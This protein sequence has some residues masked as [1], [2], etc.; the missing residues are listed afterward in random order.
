VR[1]TELS[2]GRWGLTAAASLGLLGGLA[3][4]AIADRPGEQRDLR[5]APAVHQAG[6]HR[7]FVDDFRKR[8]NRRKWDTYSG[9]PGDQPDAWWAPSHVVV[10]H[11]ALTLRTY[12][13]PN[14]GGRWVSGGVSSSRA[15]KQ[16]YG[17]YRVRFRIDRGKGVAAVFLLWPVAEHWPPEIDFAETGGA[18]N[19]RREMSAT[20]H[21]GGSDEQIQRTVH[22]DFT[23]WHTMG[24]DWTPGRLT[25][26]LD[27]R[28]WASVNAHVPDEPMEMDI[29][30][31]TGTCGD[32]Y[33]PCPDATTPA[34][35]DLHIDRVVVYAYRPAA[36]P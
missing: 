21:Y 10:R 15:L 27:G 35:V 36:K 5:R 3:A 7:V 28:R 19:A 2:L 1:R 23:R 24:V 4:A 29:Q 32:R 17:R 14:L 12:R 9:Q 22:A 6:W 25:Y 20:L 30:T 16:T 18:T 11:G 8:L 13:D 31:E 33:A 26:T 34:H